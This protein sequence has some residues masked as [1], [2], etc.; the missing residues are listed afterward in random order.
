MLNNWTVSSQTYLI[1]KYEGRDTLRCLS[2]KD[3]TQ[4]VFMAESYKL[5]SQIVDSLEQYV[6]IQQNIILDGNKT[7]SILMEKSNILEDIQSKTLSQKD[8]L[9]S[10]ISVQN[11]GCNALYLENRDLQKDL[12]RHKRRKWLSNLIAVLG[13]AGT[14]YFIIN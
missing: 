8:S 10:L 2:N 4:L 3:M 9:I 5:E 1:T 11:K 12:K 7:I 14:T 13:I 6:R